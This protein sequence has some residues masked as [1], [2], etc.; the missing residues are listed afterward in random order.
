MKETQSSIHYNYTASKS[1]DRC[2][3]ASLHCN[4]IL[5]P[6]ENPKRNAAP[7]YALQNHLLVAA[8]LLTSC[9]LL[10]KLRDISVIVLIILYVCV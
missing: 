8:S 2:C 5:K 3:I 7:W 4:V 9:Y 1:H 10:I 6:S